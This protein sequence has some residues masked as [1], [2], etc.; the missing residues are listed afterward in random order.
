MRDMEPGEPE[1]RA[2][3]ICNP[4]K[5]DVAVLR[6]IVSREEERRG[7]LPS[8]W[9]ET[10]VDDAG[11][12][13][14]REALSAKPSVVIVVGGDGTVRAAADAV[15]PSG[16]PLALVP[17]GTGNLLARNLRLPLADL[18]HSVRVAFEGFDRRIDIAFAELER[19]DGG[20]TRHAF[21]VMAGIG[22]DAN[23]AANTNSG[24][25]RRIGWLA[26]AHPIAASVIR[27]KQLPM[28][29]KLDDARSRSV[30]AHTVIVGNCGTL[31]ANIL[32]LPDAV[33]DDGLLDVVVLRPNGAVG[34]ARIGSR[35]ALNGM[36]HRTRGG[37]LLMQAAPN[38]RALQYV[39]A[40]QLV[41]RF[42]TPE[43]VEL[44]GDGFGTVVAAKL[45]VLH[46]QLTVRVPQAAISRGRAG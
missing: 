27:N 36:L 46:R 20:I 24:L 14:A 33:I 37:R 10:T 19:E 41:V 31:T 5:V 17:V 16:V 39:Q 42:N 28:H 32:L 34:W 18:E 7:L 9:L 45:T 8:L 30:R 35:L 29:Y 38:L 26:Y 3:V 2:A 21:L 11:G 13:A 6:A 25:K 4:S 15:Y 43:H 23:M 12:A 44:D 40:G 22:L 1:R